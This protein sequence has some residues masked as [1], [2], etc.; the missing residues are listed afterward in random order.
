MNKEGILVGVVKVV[1]VLVYVFLNKNNKD[2]E[3]YDVSL[4]KCI[5]LG[6]LG[7]VG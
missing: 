6:G 2:W 3:V 1:S 5:N 7:E 4:V